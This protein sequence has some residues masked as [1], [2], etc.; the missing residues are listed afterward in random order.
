MVRSMTGDDCETKTAVSTTMPLRRCVSSVEPPE[1]YDVHVTYI[2]CPIYCSYVLL[3][4]PSKYS[5][6]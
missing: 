1:V 5:V 6:N 3:L 2:A 4:I